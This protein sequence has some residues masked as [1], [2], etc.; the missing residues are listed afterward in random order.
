MK[1][2]YKAMLLTVCLSMT[3]Q[4]KD[5]FYDLSAQLAAATKTAFEAVSKQS[6][7][8]V[9]LAGKQ[10]MLTQK[11]SKESLLIALNIDVE[12]NKKNLKNSIKLFE[13]TLKGLQLGDK[14]LGL[15]ETKSKETLKQLTKVIQLWE[16]FKPSIESILNK[17]NTLE[18]LHYIS[19]NN[20]ALMKEM[21]NVVSL[22]QA[23]SGS[24]L[25]ELA[26]VINLAGKQRMLT[27]KMTKELLLIAKEVEIK[28]NKESLKQT[29]QLFDNTLQALIHGNRDLGL[30]ATKDQQI[31]KQLTTIENH[32]NEFKPIIEKTETDSTTLKK[33]AAMNLPLLSEMNKAVKM[34]EIQSK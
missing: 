3:V 2:I 23:N 5:Q 11:M 27:Q 29:T 25:N 7:I 8:R 31:I 24:D 33:V 10:R 14:S 26:I 22:Y 4:A 6:A 13:K 28:K 17:E 21:N 1:N 16:T 18:A 12:E 32:W 19:A 9:N 20:L 30:P 34:Y 15:T